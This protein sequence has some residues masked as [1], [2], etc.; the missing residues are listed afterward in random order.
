MPLSEFVFKFW[1]DITGWLGLFYLLLTF[2]TFC[3]VL[4]NKRETMSAIAWS[5]TVLVLPLVGALLFFVFGA[6]SIAR[7]LIRKQQKKSVYKRISGIVN[8]KPS[9]D[10]SP[11]WEK[12]AKLGHHG[13]GFPVTDGNAVTLYHEGRRAF[14]AMLEAIRAARDHIHIQFFI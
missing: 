9:V 6:Q 8:I 3:L 2:G 4:H 10:V 7:P 5:L 14:D 1:Q 12:L 13:D 11:R